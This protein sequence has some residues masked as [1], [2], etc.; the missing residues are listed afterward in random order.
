MTVLYE[1][2]MVEGLSGLVRQRRS[3]LSLLNDK[4]RLVETGL[5]TRHVE[6]RDIGP[7]LTVLVESDTRLTH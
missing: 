5:E 3:L 1:R 4:S 7:L 6:A 2:T